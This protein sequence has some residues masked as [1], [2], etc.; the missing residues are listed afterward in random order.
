MPL[1]LG[2][3]WLLDS[4][5]AVLQKKNPNVGVH[6]VQPGLQAGGSDVDVNKRRFDVDLLIHV[7][8]E[9]DNTWWP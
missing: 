7:G 8:F 9:D 2:H 6:I 5:L 4:V 1:W 3:I